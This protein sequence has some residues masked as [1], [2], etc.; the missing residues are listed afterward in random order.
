MELA[1]TMQKQIEEHAT[2]SIMNEK[3]GEILHT[4]KCAMVFCSPSG[5]L[6]CTF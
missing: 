5:N 3:M 6:I 2:G 4:G 1:G